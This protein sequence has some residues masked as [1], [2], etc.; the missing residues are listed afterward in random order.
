MNVQFAVFQIRKYFFF[1][2]D[3]FYGIM[4]G[5][6]FKCFIYLHFSLCH[7]ILIS[8]YATASLAEIKR[9]KKSTGVLNSRHTRTCILTQSYN[10]PITTLRVTCI[11][12]LKCK[13]LRIVLFFFLFVS[14]LFFFNIVNAGFCLISF[15]LA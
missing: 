11:I 14:L 6:G 7:A 9:K 4:I 15:I 3:S 12:Y 2:Q 8:F 5:H 1:Q 10:I 13:S